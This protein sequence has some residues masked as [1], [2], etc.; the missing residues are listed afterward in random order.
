MLSIASYEPHIDTYQMWVNIDD[1]HE[2]PE[3]IHSKFN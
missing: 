2:N 3:I 1:W